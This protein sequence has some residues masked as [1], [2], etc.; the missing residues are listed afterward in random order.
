MTGA[1]IA[2]GA[3]IVGGGMQAL[4][5]LQ[6]GNAAKTAGDS[7]GAV[8]DMNAKMERSLAAENARRSRR[9]GKKAAGS[10]RNN[11][12]VSM[13]V[14]ED[15]VKE[16]ELEA[17]SIEYM[18]ETKAIN[19]QNQAEMARFRGRQAKSASRLAAVSTLLMT[20]AGAYGLSGGAGAANGATGGISPTASPSMSGGWVG[21]PNTYGA[22]GLV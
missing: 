16:A 6:S 1:E 8:L 19:F 21:S 13:D 9:V 14:L 17:Q 10:Y 20:G 2:I 18:G 11:V 7:N 22:G 15:N 4:G 5:Q 3:L 12:H